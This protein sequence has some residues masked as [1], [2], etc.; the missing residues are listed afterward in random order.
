MI[1]ELE[2]I[3]IDDAHKD[4]QKMFSENF[5]VSRYVCCCYPEEFIKPFFFGQIETIFQRIPQG[6]NQINR[7]QLN[8]TNGCH[9]NVHPRDSSFRFSNVLNNNASSYNNN[10]NQQSS[11]HI[12]A[13]PQLQQSHSSDGSMLRHMTSGQHYPSMNNDNLHRRSD[14]YQTTPEGSTT[15]E[16]SSESSAEEWESGEFV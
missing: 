15:P 12:V 14:N 7:L 4:K 3:E 5:K 13:E 10:I 9:N 8:N 1:F 16:S 2:K 6:V 11:N